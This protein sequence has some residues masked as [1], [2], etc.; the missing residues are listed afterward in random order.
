MK[1]FTLLTVTMRDG[2]FTRACQQVAK[3][4][5]KPTKWVII[6]EPEVRMDTLDADVPCPV[7]F[8]PAPLQTRLS[9]LNAS[10]NEGL[11]K[12]ETDY[13][14]FYQDFIDLP[15]GCFKK[16]MEL[17][18]NK[19]FVTTVSKNDNHTPEE[20]PRITGVKK[21]RQCRPEEWEA[22]VAVAPMD[23]LKLL[24]GFDEEY[25]NAWSWDNVNVADRAQLLGCKFICDETNRPQL[26]YHPKV[27][28]LPLNAEWHAKT[29]REIRTGL[30]SL[31]CDYL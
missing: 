7:E 29:M 25:D 8:W 28:N 3:Q 13:V 30:R 11:R 24:G 4:G 27:R 20:D 2:W 10:L 21:P 9:N 26:L 17:A 15:R 1:Q 16:L 18:A 31:H 6:H 22:N 12:V 19:T 14:L 23:I 5:C